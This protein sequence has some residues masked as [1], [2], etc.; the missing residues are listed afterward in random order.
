MKY[1]LNHSLKASITDNSDATDVCIEI[2][3][4]PHIKFLKSKYI[5][6]LSW[7]NSK[8]DFRI[9][10]YLKGAVIKTEYNS[11]DKW[12]KVLEIINSQI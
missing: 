6:L 8:M 10:I 5:G 2:S 9:K 1:K 7:Y 11:L 12:K 4:I 3:G